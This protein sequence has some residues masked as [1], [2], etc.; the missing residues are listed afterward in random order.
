MTNVFAAESRSTPGRDRPAIRLQMTETFWYGVRKIE[1]GGGGLLFGVAKNYGQYEL[2]FIEN[3]GFVITFLGKEWRRKDV[4]LFYAT[5]PAEIEQLM[6]EVKLPHSS[7]TVTGW[8]R[9]FVR[10]IHEA[11]RKD[12]KIADFMDAH[13]EVFGARKL[14]S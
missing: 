8:V 2:K 1:Y 11:A 4:N 9:E 13:P 14:E 10:D 6:A 5:D 12:V 3:M 7:E